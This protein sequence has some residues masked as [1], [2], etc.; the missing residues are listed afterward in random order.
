MANNGRGD[1]V[2][3]YLLLGLAALGAET[4]HRGAVLTLSLARCLRQ[5]LAEALRGLSLELVGQIVE[6]ACTVFHRL[7][8][9]KEGS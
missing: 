1:L 5:E 9:T 8:E 3:A 4:S 2:D 6:D 7:H